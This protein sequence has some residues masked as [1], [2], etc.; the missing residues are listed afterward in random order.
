LNNGELVLQSVLK[1]WINGADGK[2]FYLSAIE[3]DRVIAPNDEVLVV[4]NEILKNEGNKIGE[5]H[6]SYSY[7]SGSFTELP[8][9]LRQ[10]ADESKM[11]QSLHHDYFYYAEYGPDLVSLSRYNLKSKER[12]D[13][14]ALISAGQLG[15]AE[16]KNVQ[17]HSNRVYLLIVD[18]AG[19]PGAAVLDL[20]NGKLLYKGRTVET[21][22]DKQ[23]AEEM[24]ENLHLLNL[25]ITEQHES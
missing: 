3:P 5:K 15:A 23:T 22:D 4:A 19:I 9:L 18:P 1:S 14:Y 25:D 8:G 11:S 16:I 12:E 13:E 7:R 17:I 10:T 20:A 2:D 21:G 6:Y 24:K